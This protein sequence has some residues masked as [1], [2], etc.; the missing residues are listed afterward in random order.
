MSVTNLYTCIYEKQITQLGGKKE[1]Y[2]I[3]LK[4]NYFIAKMI[5]VCI[6]ITHW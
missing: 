5:S 1:H 2:F 4:C 3:S 6:D